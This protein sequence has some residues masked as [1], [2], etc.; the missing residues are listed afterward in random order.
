MVGTFQISEDLD[1]RR[2]RDIFGQVISHQ[3]TLE[4][5]RQFFTIAEAPKI[6]MCAKNAQALKRRS[7]ASSKM[8]LTL[9]FG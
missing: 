3:N 7:S 8:A 6:I 9:Y 5:I 4:K 2:S 1:L